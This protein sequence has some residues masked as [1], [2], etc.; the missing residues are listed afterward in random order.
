MVFWT[1]H[2]II[3]AYP[4]CIPY[5]TPL[6]WIYVENSIDLQSGLDFDFLTLGVCQSFKPFFKFFNFF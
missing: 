4:N 1:V 2:R 3:D 6:A 5:H